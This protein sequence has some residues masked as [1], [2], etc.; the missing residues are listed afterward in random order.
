MIPIRYHRLALGELFAASKRH[1]RERPG[2]GI[3]I[4]TEFDRIVR[5]ISTAPRQ[6]SPY[7][8]GTRRFIFRRFPYSTV[9]V[10]LDEYGHVIA[11]A[12]HSRKPGYW[13]RRLKD[14]R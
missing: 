11:V 3:R 14:V 1:E 9:Y 10:S 12:H 7:L 4:V 5:R 6:G 8:F 2:R 13:R